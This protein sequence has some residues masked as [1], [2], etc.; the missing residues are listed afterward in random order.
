MATPDAMDERCHIDSVEE[1]VLECVLSQL[2]PSD[3]ASLAATSAGMRALVR[4][5]RLTVRVDAERLSH[6][7]GTGRRDPKAQQEAMLAS[8]PTLAPRCA[9][10]DLTG[11]RASDQSVARALSRLAHL[12]EVILDGCHRVSTS[13]AQALVDER[14]DSPV[15]LVSLQRCFGLVDGAALLALALGWWRRVFLARHLSATHLLV[16]GRRLPVSDAPGHLTTLSLTCCAFQCSAA[17]LVR[18]VAAGAPRLE[19]LGVGGSSFGARVVRARGAG[20]GRRGGGNTASA[21]FASRDDDDE[22]GDDDDDD[23]DDDASVFDVDDV[24][25]DAR[26]RAEALSGAFVALPKLRAL[27]ATFANPEDPFEPASS[28]LAPAVSR[29]AELANAADADAVTVTVPVPVPVRTYDLWDAADARCVL[30]LAAEDARDGPR[31]AGDVSALRAAANCA[32]PRGFKVT[33]LHAAVSALAPDPR[34]DRAAKESA[35]ASSEETRGTRPRRGGRARRALVRMLKD[36]VGGVARDDEDEAEEEKREEEKRE[37]KQDQDDDGVGSGSGSVSGS[38]SG[39]CFEFDF[40]LEAAGA[41][42]AATD[43]DEGEAAIRA[44]IAMGADVNARDRSGATPLFLAAEIGR[45]A[46]VECLLAAGAEPA[47]RNNLGESPLYIAALKGRDAALGALLRHCRAEGLP[48][49]DPEWYGDG[50]TPLHAAACANHPGIAKTLLDAA[51]EVQAEASEASAE[52]SAGLARALTT[53]SNSTTGAKST[54][55]TTPTTPPRKAPSPSSRTPPTSPP[56]AP[57]PIVSAKNRYGATALHIAALLGS[58]PLVEALL[59]AGAPHKTR[60][61]NGMRPIDVAAREGH[62]ALW[63]ILAGVDGEDDPEE[64]FR[65]RGGRRR[66]HR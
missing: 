39:S 26:R 56:G 44:L 62:A 30:R 45:G 17:E 58:A 15:D 13:T 24:E 3:L 41:S 38:G 29:V 8:L 36:R 55:T 11:S 37:E 32:P 34:E 46:T 19:V 64:M 2:R 61:G 43:A 65:S 57:P 22:E 31:A 59:A 28:W 1:G 5:A 53:G 35:S 9:R 48:W 50:W 25:S 6:R 21:G 14:R 63:E 12:R 7:A 47:A 33:P 66:T 16:P 18:A 23:D 40:D 27:E 42:S 51:A 4:R 20:A 60:D 52:A 49:Q 10:L 54:T